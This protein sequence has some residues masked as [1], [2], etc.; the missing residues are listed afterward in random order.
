MSTIHFI[1]LDTHCSFCEMA[2]MTKN[3][4]LLQRQK[5]ATAIPPLVN[6]IEAF[7]KPRYLTLEE[8]PPG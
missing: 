7:R 4:K 3:G 2:V 1:A 6:A 5:L 8:G